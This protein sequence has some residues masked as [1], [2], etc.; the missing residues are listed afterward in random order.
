MTTIGEAARAVARVARLLQDAGAGD[1]HIPDLTPTGDDTKN[2]DNLA[3]DLGYLTIANLDALDPDQAATIR[4]GAIDALAVLP[5]TVGA[6]FYTALKT[7]LADE[8]EGDSHV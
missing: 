7:A 2:R 6:E 8:P 4:A 1:A 5:A 3:I